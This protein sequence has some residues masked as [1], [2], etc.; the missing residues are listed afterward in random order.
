[1][2]DTGFLAEELAYVA[3]QLRLAGETELRA[4]LQKAV[5]DATRDIPRQIR[6]GLKPKLP[7]RYVLED[8]GPDLRVTV[9]KH[10]GGR[11]PGV[12][13]KATTRSGKSRKLSRLNR[14]A[15]GHPL[16]GNRKRWFDQQVGPGWFSEPVLDAGAKARTE[17]LAALDRVSV[18]ATR[19][20]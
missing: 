11:D 7:D 9:S 2:G 12:T 10:Y 16:F 13:V 8:F 18:K 1:M 17:I 20:G 3:R 6:S 14:G 5:S 4:E 19:K 15:L